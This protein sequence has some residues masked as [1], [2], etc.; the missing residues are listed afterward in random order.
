MLVELKVIEQSDYNLLLGCMLVTLW[1]L[2]FRHI[3]V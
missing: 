3:L 1:L 2:L